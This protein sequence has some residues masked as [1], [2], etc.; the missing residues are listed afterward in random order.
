MSPVDRLRCGILELFTFRGPSDGWMVGWLDGWMVGWL[1]GW[2]VGCGKVDIS[3][4]TLWLK[5][6]EQLENPPFW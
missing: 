2:M 6:I 5:P 3:G 1:D 4:R